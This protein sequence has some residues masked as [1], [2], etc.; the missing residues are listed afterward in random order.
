MKKT[1]T[2]NLR[3]QN[4]PKA[5]RRLLHPLPGLPDETMSPVV[6]NLLVSFIAF[7]SFLPL[8]LSPSTGITASAFARLSEQQLRSNSILVD[9]NHNQL[10]N[11]VDPRRKGL[12]ITESPADNQGLLI[13]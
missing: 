6:L 11:V 13:V 12:G 8:K 1:K 9:I 7:F 10:R 4:T 5:F 2:R 3:L